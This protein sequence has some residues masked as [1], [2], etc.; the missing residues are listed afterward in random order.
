MVETED[1]QVSAQ[2]Q[3]PV[4]VAVVVAVELAIRRVRLELLM[5]LVLLVD[6]AVVLQQVEPQELNPVLQFIRVG[7]A[8]KTTAHL[9]HVVEVVAQ[10]QLALKLELEQQLVAALA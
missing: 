2:S 7:Q 6:Q 10:V 1:L 4:V 8:L 9:V 5:Q 3:L